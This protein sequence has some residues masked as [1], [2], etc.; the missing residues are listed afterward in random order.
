MIS[1]EPTEDELALQQTVHRF[2]AERIRPALRECEEANGVTEELTRAFWEIGLAQMTCP[3]PVGGAGLG[4][5][6]AVLAEEELAWGDPGISVALPRPGFTGEALAALGEDVQR[7]WLA[8]LVADPP[9]IASAAV[10]EGGSSA[11]GG[12]ACQVSPRNG[13]IVVSGT[14]HD[15]AAA[16]RADWILVTGRLGGELALLALPRDTP[17]IG[18][19]PAP[20]RLGLRAARYGRLSLQECRA[21]NEA[22]LARGDAAG[23]ALSRALKCELVMWAARAV[24]T[25]RAAFEYAARYATERRA[26]GRAIAEHQAVA[27]MVADMGIQVDAARTLVWQ[28]ASAV[29][30]QAPDTAGLA[31]SAADFATD[32]ALKVTNDAVQ[33][34]GGHGY[35]Q[36]HPVEK[37]MRDAR[38]LA[39]IAQRVVGTLRTLASA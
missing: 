14:K 37:W 34:L 20:L 30:T 21:S 33:V 3:S 2:A 29:D 35:I 23:A 28:A 39:N 22:V 32:A 18:F 16:D 11:D 31:S 38:A 15:V 4:W 26:F 17:G 24:G 8:P 27:F 36:D 25:A 9:Q 13:G 5:R 6:T 7:R 10:F 19:V 12:S 1:F